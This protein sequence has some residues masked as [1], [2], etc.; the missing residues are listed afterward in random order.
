MQINGRNV[1]RLPARDAYAFALL[2]MDAMFS[3]EELSVS[4]LY[5][6]DKSK[7]PGLDEEKVKHMMRLVEKRFG[8]KGWNEKILISKAN[9]K[10]RDSKSIVI[11]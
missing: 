10:C 2:L 8:E 6:S 5:K 7:K 3:K 11:K 1:M 4:L 9:Q